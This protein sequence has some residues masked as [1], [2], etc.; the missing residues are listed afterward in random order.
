MTVTHAGSAN[1][2][3]VYVEAFKEAER[4]KW[5]ESQKHGRDLGDHAIRQWYATYWPLYCREKRIEHLWGHR[6]WHEFQDTKFGHINALVL[7]GDILVDRV[8][9]RVYSG[10]EN[11]DVINWA[12][13]W[14]MPMDR[15]IGILEQVDV[16]RARL[17][18]KA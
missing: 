8:L 18:P 11:L 3:S 7:T 9:D 16:N 6:E 2:S 5:I 1:P 12:L 15:V 13:T 17:E 10:Y 14:G 4:Y